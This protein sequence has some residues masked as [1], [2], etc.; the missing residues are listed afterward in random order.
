VTLTCTWPPTAAS[1]R[2]CTASASIPATG[3]TAGPGDGVGD[4]DG[5]DDG[6]AD[7]GAPPHAAHSSTASAAAVHL[8]RRG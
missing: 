8:M 3:G 1:V 5:A 6:D 2:S 4:E 7:D